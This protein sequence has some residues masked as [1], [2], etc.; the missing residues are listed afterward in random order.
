M[1][2]LGQAVYRYICAHS[3]NGEWGVGKRVIVSEMVLRGYLH[4]VRDRVNLALQDYLQMNKL[5]LRKGRYI[6]KRA[7]E[8]TFS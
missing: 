8:A 4:P 3:R 5:V 7:L 2:S 1:Q 6:H